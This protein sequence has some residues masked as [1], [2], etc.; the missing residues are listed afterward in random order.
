M[1]FYTFLKPTS[2]NSFIPS[3]SI[4]SR[5]SADKISSPSSTPLPGNYQKESEVVLRTSKYL[6]WYSIIARTLILSIAE[7]YQSLYKPIVPIKLTH[8]KA[9]VQHFISS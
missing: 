5:L 8:T 6:S 2:A 9:K 4:S 7:V 1:Q 3:S